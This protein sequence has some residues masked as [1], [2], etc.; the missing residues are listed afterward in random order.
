VAGVD[1]PEARRFAAV[2]KD[3]PAGAVRLRA[4]GPAGIYDRD[5]RAPD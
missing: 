2:V 3:D 4:L 1:H 5:A